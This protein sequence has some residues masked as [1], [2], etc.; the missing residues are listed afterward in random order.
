MGES[1]GMGEGRYS[2]SHSYEVRFGSA[3][4]HAPRAPTHSFNCLYRISPGTAIEEFR[5]KVLGKSLEC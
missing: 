4:A 3:T 5:K 1:W 2:G